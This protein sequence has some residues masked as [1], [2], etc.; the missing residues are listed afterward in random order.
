MSPLD[1]QNAAFRCWEHEDCLEHPELALAC[2]EGRVPIALP[3]FDGWVHS[4]WGCGD[5]G[6]I[7][8]DGGGVVD[9]NANAGRAHELPRGMVVA[10][11]DWLVRGAEPLRTDYE[12][13]LYHMG[14][15]F[16]T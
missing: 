3:L 15:A 2:A 6:T 16:L 10:D 1:P 5:A 14:M 13:L 9:M 8:G 4:R 7:F 11:R 12:E